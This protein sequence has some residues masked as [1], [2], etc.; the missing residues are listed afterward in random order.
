MPHA[1]LLYPWAAPVI[2]AGLLERVEKA[3]AEFQALEVPFSEIGRF[4]T[5]VWLR[6][7]PE[8]EIRELSR[9]LAEAF[10]EYP[11]YG[12]LYP[13]P[14]PHVAVAISQ[15]PARLD[16]IEAELRETIAGQEIRFMVTTVDIAERRLDRQWVVN[17]RIGLTSG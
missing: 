9:A 13:D 8:A 7:E 14:Q 12:G 3:V 10:P 16:E 6:P 2:G 15:D 17:S 4:P 1:S 5:V 11:R